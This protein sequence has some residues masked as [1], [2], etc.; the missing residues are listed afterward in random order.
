MPMRHR[1]EPLMV[2]SERRGAVL[3]PDRSDL[4]AFAERLNGEIIL[5]EDERYD[6]ERMVFNAAI[7]RRPAAIVRVA[8][9]QDVVETIAF[10]RKH[11]LLVSVRGG[12]HGTMGHSMI[13]DGLVIDLSLRKF[14]EVDVE[15]R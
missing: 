10:A 2:I 4:L 6:E 8:D 15:K 11:D 9:A 3:F 5:P 7:D 12:G 13:D 14:V 1:K